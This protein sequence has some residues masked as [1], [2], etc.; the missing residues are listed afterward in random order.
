MPKGSLQ[1][2]KTK[3]FETRLIKECKG[4]IYPSETDGTFEPFFGGEAKKGLREVLRKA[5]GSDS[6][7][8]IEEVEFD[9]FFESLITEK[10]WFTAGQRKM[11]KRFAKLRDLMESE[12]KEIKVFRVGRIRIEIY[13]VG[14][15]K[16]GM[17]MGVKTFAVET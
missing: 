13:I 2:E 4:L 8:K 17:I 14:I 3:A 11:A 12:L 10:D 7:T 9:K 15:D 16:T 6:K 5:P 1:K